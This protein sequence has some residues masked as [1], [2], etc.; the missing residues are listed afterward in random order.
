MSCTVVG[1]LTILDPNAFE[2]YR[3]AVPDTLTPYQGELLGRGVHAHTLANEHSLEAID[4]VALIKFPS[5]E[6]AQAWATGPEY[7]A[8]LPVRNQGIR[9]SLNAFS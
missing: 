5:A 1:L 9:L 2:T 4:G 3:D 8:I 6:L 7:Q